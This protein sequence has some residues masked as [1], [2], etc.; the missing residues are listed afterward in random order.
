MGPSRRGAV[1][2]EMSEDIR[3]VA[4]ERIAREHPHLDRR[5]QVRALV[6]QLY[7]EALAAK[8]FDQDER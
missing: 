7:G 3:R 4:E 6:S 8:A 5:G 1:A 2:I